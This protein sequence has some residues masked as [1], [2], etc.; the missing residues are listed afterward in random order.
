VPA[1]AF[2]LHFVS[3][4]I[5]F[6]TAGA[7][8]QTTTEWSFELWQGTPE[9]GTLM[10][11]F[12]SDGTIL[13]HLIMPPGTTGTIVQLIIDPGDPEQIFIADNGSHTYSVAFRIEQHNSPG[14]PCLV[15]P[16]QQANAFPTTDMSGVGS[17]T[18]NWIDA[19]DGSFCVC[20]VGW[21]NFA[22]FPSVCTPS[23]D[24]VIRSTYIPLECVAATGACC[25]A[26]GTC[27][28]LTEVDCGTLEGKWSGAQ[29]T[30]VAADCQPSPGACC[31]AATGACTEVNEATCLAFGGEFH[32][33][34]S[35]ATWICF[36][37]GACCL[38]NGDCTGPVAQDVC[39][40][41]G[42]TF[43]GH[44][45]D[46]ATTDCP[47]PTGWCCPEDGSF[48]SDMSE[49]QCLAFGAIWGGIGTSCDDASACN[50]SSCDGDVNDSGAV[51]VDDLLLILSS[52]GGTGG[53]DA[54]GDG[55]VDVDDLLMAIANF[56]P[57]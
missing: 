4:E 16:D 34:E 13:P 41:F 12:A 54:D 29:V 17:Q 45:T 35:C 53:G 14:Q 6:A 11:V 42:G 47:D 3:A 50:A 1:E 52:W 56:G 43:M 28:P 23:G 25:F 20:G 19:I 18:G 27:Q 44:G 57:C 40:G 26:N 15:P 37:E 38:V 2:P 5:L 7:T 55:D 30:C 21:F 22:Q 49:E 36:P 48:C 8:T 9:Q 31:V 39:D 51:D 46:C 24:W 32:A 10:H 33:E